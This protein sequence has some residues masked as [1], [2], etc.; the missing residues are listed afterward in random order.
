[1]KLGIMQPYFFPYLGYFD[2]IHQTDK[3][4]VCDTLQ[5]IRHGWIN[6]NRVLHP[7]HG[8]WYII[9]PLTRH[10]SGAPIAEIE[11]APNQA[12]RR[13]IVRQLQHYKKRAPYFDETMGLVEEGLSSE[14][15]SI[16]RLNVN[17]LSLVCEYLGIAFDYDLYSEMNLEI[18]PV[19]APGDWALRISE[20]L[21]AD[22]YVNPPGGAVLYDP[23]DFRSAGMT[24]TIRHLPPLEYECH[25]YEFVPNL[26]IIDLLMWNSP[27]QIKAH[28]DIHGRQQGK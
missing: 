9:V 3:W 28:L 21:G 1:M 24:L 13:R 27:E 2:L 15:T 10:S 8:W 25:G 6:R 19:Q 14:Q 20:A 18:G 17:C 7:S 4:I 22:E 16:V 23:E 5:Y 12:W 26:S 11:I